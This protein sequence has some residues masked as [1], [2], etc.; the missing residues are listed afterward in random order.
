MEVTPEMS[1]EE[2]VMRYPKSVPIFF[3]HGLPPI[4][5]GEPV[6]GTIAENAAKRNL[7]DLDTL[8]RELNRIAAS[9]EGQP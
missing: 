8:I 7:A 3:A 2:V 5:C 9:D 1:V 4:A 6:W